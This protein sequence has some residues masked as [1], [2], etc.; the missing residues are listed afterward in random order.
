MPE[1]AIAPFKKMLRRIDSNMKISDKAKR[2][3]RNMTNRFSMEVLRG[4]IEIAKASDRKTVMVQ[5]LR[6]SKRQLVKTI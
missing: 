5:D 3:I 2:E 6:I 1:L 4:A